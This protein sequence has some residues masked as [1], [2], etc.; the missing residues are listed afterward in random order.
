M[1]RSPCYE[2]DVHLAGRDKNGPECLNCKKRLEFV[3]ALQSMTGP[4]PMEMTDMGARR[5]SPELM[6]KAEADL[7][8]CAPPEPKQIPGRWTPDQDEL[9]RTLAP[10][11][12]AQRLGKSIGAIY[13][14]RSQLK[15][16]R[17]VS[18][19]PKSTANEH[20]NASAKIAVWPLTPFPPFSCPHCGHGIMFEAVG[21]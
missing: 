2:C 13:V 12:A 1:Q 3:G 21:I 16:K 10:A 19:T 11:D 15:I 18:P 17:Q 8:R 7:A 9:V 20:H 4:V 6:A 14:R 5:I